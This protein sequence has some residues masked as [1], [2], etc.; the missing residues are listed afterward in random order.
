ML[1]RMADRSTSAAHNAH[2]LLLLAPQQRE[3][4]ARGGGRARA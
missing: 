4:V 1:E 2:I 3:D